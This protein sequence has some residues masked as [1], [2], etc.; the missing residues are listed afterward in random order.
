V[1]EGLGGVV[2]PLDP[3][4]GGAHGPVLRAAAAVARAAAAAP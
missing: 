4:L 1:A 2:D 3:R